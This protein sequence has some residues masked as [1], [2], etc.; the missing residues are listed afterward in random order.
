MNR[1]FRS[2]II[3]L[4]LLSSGCVT[5]RHVSPMGVS[6]DVSISG[7]RD[8][9]A[10][11]GASSEY[12]KKDFIGLLER[13]EKDDP[14]FLKSGETISLLAVSGGASY[15]AYGAG[16]LNGWSSQGSRPAFKVVT[17]ISAG[18]IIAS[19][20][21][22]GS[23]YDGKLKEFFTQYST[24]DLMRRKNIIFGFFSN[25]LAS[26]R[27]L[28]RLINKNINREFVKKV[29]GEY[30]KG[31]RLYIG[32]TDLDVQRLV[33][34]DMGKIATRGNESALQLFQKIVLASV[35][36]PTLWPPVYF[37]IQEKDK[38]YDEMHVDG[39]IAKQ[40]FF[41]YDVVKGW[42]CAAKEKGLNAEKMKYKI[43]VI[44][45]GYAQAVYKPV[46]NRLSC[47]SLRAM[48]TMAN[49]EGI[50]DLYQLYLYTKLRKGD[51]NLAYIPSSHISNA[52]EL[53]DLEEMRSLF[54][55][56]ETQ[57]FKG[58]SWRKVPPGL[59]E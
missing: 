32:T 23:D 28:E 11:S 37:S 9:R 35:S 53:F 14:D 26:D 38:T 27:R 39:G 6:H 8:I 2:T 55:L 44:R 24:K 15:G 45:N 34:W 43:Y 12:M 50:G 25:S 58:Y 36:I 21:F 18:A 4:V 20:A 3:I 56:G 19:F 16:L 1:V 7:M 48:D 41:L 57:A 46:A 49:A 29:A 17:G 52:R 13:E 47:I 31:R 54:N 33:I 5:A 10:I 51:F 59:E 42:D 40:V 22:L 30:R